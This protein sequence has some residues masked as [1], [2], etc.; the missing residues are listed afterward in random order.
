MI[1]QVAGLERVGERHPCEVSKGEHESK[2]LRRNVHGGQNGGLHPHRIQHIDGVKRAH[3]H[4]GHAHVACL[5]NPEALIDT[6]RGPPSKRLRSVLP[7]SRRKACKES[8]SVHGGT[9]RTSSSYWALTHRR[10][11]SGRTA[12]RSLVAVQVLTKMPG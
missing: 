5:H 6:H 4:Q 3:Q 10:D 11:V 9:K 12:W 1:D 2:A 7:I 8:P